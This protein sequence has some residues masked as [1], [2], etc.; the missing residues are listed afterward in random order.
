VQ[1]RKCVE[2]CEIPCH[3]FSFKNVYFVVGYFALLTKIPKIFVPDISL[4]WIGM[5]MVFRKGKD[6]GR[7]CVTLSQ[8][9]AAMIIIVYL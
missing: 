7:T 6:I 2:A 3:Y 9:N 8:L 5:I 4:V 1:E